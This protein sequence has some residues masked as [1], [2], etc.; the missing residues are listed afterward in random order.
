MNNE[1]RHIFTP[2]E[3][4]H[5]KDEITPN[6]NPVI[7]NQDPIVILPQNDP[8]LN[9][10]VSPYVVVGRDI[11]S[12]FLPY[13]E[14]AIIRYRPYFYGEIKNYSQSVGL[15]VK[16]KFLFI[17]KGI[18]TI[19]FD[20]MELTISDFMYIGLL[21][22]MSALGDSDIIITFMCNR[23]GNIV[24]HRSKCSE[25]DIE[26]L[27]VPKLPVRI[28]LMDDTELAF[29][30]MTVG[31]YL[32]LQETGQVNDDIAFLA[33]CCIN[34]P[35]D[36]VYK[37]LTELTHYQD[38]ELLDRVDEMLYH[39]VKPIRVTCKH[40]ETIL[41]EV[42]GLTMA[43]LKDMVNKSPDQFKALCVMHYPG[44]VYAEGITNLESYID[45]IAE[46][47]GIITYKVCD[48]VN[49]VEIDSGD[50]LI[51]PFRTNQKSIE[52]RIQFG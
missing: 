9:L 49:L 32:K 14:G 28:T 52:N 2:Q 24:E 10:E 19:G 30:P 45:Y 23:C 11:P 38:A 13:P 46:K 36:E 47:L 48:R 37:I 1:R 43:G 16:D 35:F 50:V 15:S 27:Q 41:N 7:N 5:K 25:V 3:Q 17:L 6:I 44:F 39:S 21:R 12:K 34:L 42:G 40:R 4:I 8:P 22:R 33:R 51:S 26:Y 31:G 18:E 29:S 20:K